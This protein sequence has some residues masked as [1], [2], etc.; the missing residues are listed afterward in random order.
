MHRGWIEVSI[1]Q[2]NEGKRVN[3]L[4]PNS[5]SNVLSSDFAC[6]MNCLKKGGVLQGVF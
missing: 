5:L 2:N 6:A 4:H 3:K 1:K